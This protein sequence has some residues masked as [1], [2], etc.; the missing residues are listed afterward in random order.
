MELIFKAV[1]A[2]VSTTVIIIIIKRHNHELSVLLS[3][4]AVTVIML[5]AVN[6]SLELRELIKSAAKMVDSADIYI[7][8]ILKCLAISIITKLGTDLCKDAGQAALASALEFTGTVCA[9]TVVLP[10]LKNMIH[11]IGDMV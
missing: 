9:M 7:V 5:A 2:A 4:C 3:I 10:L 11:L 1:G 8:S 6:F